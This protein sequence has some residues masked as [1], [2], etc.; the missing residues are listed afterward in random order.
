MLT[1]Y[2]TPSS[3]EAF[4]S[5]GRRRW[6][7]RWLIAAALSLLLLGGVGWASLAP[8]E[9]AS[10]DEVFEIPHGTWAR[11]IAG[12]QVEILPQ[13]IRLTSGIND[14]LLLR[15]ADEVPHVFGPTL[16][17][18]G[19]SFSLPFASASTYSFMCTAHANGQL[20]VVVEAKPARGWETLRWRLRRLTRLVVWHGQLAGQHNH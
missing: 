16:V 13:T 14:V 5:R 15:N 10:H 8:I 2:A 3:P 11:R 12:E 20:T 4:S 19:Q 1:P 7:W 18:P 17:M 9:V 6:S